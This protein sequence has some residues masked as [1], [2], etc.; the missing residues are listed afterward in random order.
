MQELVT[1]YMGITLANPIVAGACG[2]TSNISS[3]RELEEAGIGAIVAKTLF[4]EQIQLERLKFGEDLEKYNYRNAEMIN[5]FGH[6]TYQ[7]PREHLMWLRETKKAVTIPVFAS[8]N[9]VNK[10]TWIEYAKLL[11]DTGVD[12][13]EIDLFPPLDDPRMGSEL[14]EKAHVDLVAELKEAISIPI[15]IKLSNSY[16]NVLNIVR[17]M[18]GAQADAFVLFNK[19]FTPDIDLQN[20]KIRSPVAFSTEPDSRPPLRYTALL[21]GAVKADL[22]CSTG[23]MTGEQILAMILAGAKT[24]QIVSALYLH[25]T[26]CISTMLSSMEKWM[27]TNDYKT[28]GEFR[29][30]LSKRNVDDPWA[31]TRTQYIK[32]LMDTDELIHNS[33]V[34]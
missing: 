31:Y 28:L 10:N 15:S 25:G 2:L 27:R 22:C 17:R 8:L 32:I 13:L 19:P 26:A 18:D 14:I 3:I 16:T 21:E 20:L 12:G 24:V 7:G 34:L 30:A 4:E 5:V 1:T 9:A 33:P 23:I 11:E 6:T 29:G